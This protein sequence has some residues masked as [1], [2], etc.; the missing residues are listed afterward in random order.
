[1][2]NKGNVPKL[3]FSAFTEN[4][5]SAKLGDLCEI[6]PSNKL[7]PNIFIY[8][9]LESVSNG[10]LLKENIISKSDAPSRA[11]RLL[12][13]EDVLFQM[14]RPYQKNNLFF[15]KEGDY[16][17]STGYAQLRTNQNSKFIFQY[18]HSQ[19]FVDKVVKKCTGTSYPSINSSDLSDIII[20]YPL[21]IINSQNEQTKIAS[22]LTAVDEKLQALKKKKSLLEQY[23]KGVMQQLFSQELRFKDQQG[24]PFPDWE[25]KMLGEMISL[26]VDN[27][28]KTPPVSN[29]G[30]PLLEVNSIGNKEINYNAVSKYVSIETYDNWFRKYLDKGDIL[31]S[32]VGNTALC[33]YY[34]GS[35]AAVIAQNIVGL[36]FKKEF[37]L[38]MFYLLTETKNKNKFKQIEMGA[39]QPSVKVSQMIDLFFNVPT[40]E[41][42]TK[43]AN[44]LSAIDEKIN[45]TKI[46]I[47]Q[48][49]EWKKGLLQRMFV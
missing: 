3:R 15:D 33:S 2:K 18:L 36:R 35:Q 32:T 26:I 42:Q 28:G 23:K 8:I 30:I 49:Q 43:I 39:V 17:A 12:K 31:F 13:K 37:N 11:Q 25:M 1:M 4:W 41:E 44:F 9:D 27:R 6:N 38:F 40:K 19:K 22:F 16:V 7:L 20:N 46:Q 24:N 45:R 14:V 48:T 5:I 47:E 34:N 21:S 29:I 10:E